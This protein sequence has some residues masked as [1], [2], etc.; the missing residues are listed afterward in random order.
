[1]LMPK[2]KK[3]NLLATLGLFSI[4]LVISVALLA[5]MFLKKPISEFSLDTRKA[6]MVDSGLAELDTYPFNQSTLKVN[7]EQKINLQ[8]NTKD[9]SVDTIKLIFE[10]IADKGLLDK[11]R[12][13]FSGT[14]PAELEINKQEVIESICEKDCYTVTLLLNIKNSSVAF[15]TH[16]QMKTISQLSFTPKNEGSL[17]IKISQDSTAIERGTSVDILQKPSVLDFQYY[18]TENGIDRSQCSFEYTAWGE[19]QN[20]W[21]TRKYSVQPDRCQWY[22][23][24][25]LKE[26]SQKCIDND[27]VTANNNYFYLYSNDVCLN[28]PSNGGSLYIIWNKNKYSNVTWIDVSN[29]PN[30]EDYYHKKVEGNIDQTNGDWII[31]N[32]KDF[33]NSANNK[34]P[35]SIE[36]SREYFFRLYST[37]NDGEHISSVRYYVNYCS[38]NQSSYKNC[39]EACGEGSDQSKSCAPGLTCSNNVCRNSSNPDNSLCLTTPGIQSADRSCNQ[40][41]ANSNECGSGLSCFWNHCRR[42]NNLESSSC[43]TKSTSSTSNNTI[44]KSAA[45]ITKGGNNVN[46]YID[47]SGKTVLLPSEAYVL[48]T[49]GCNQGC[50]G[51]RD[52]D[53]DMRCYKGKCR[54]VDNPEEISCAITSNVQKSA[55]SSSVSSINSTNNPTISP[56]ITKEIKEKNT[57]FQSGINKFLSNFSWQWLAFAGVIL[58]IA[59]ALIV[60]S[61]TNAKKDLW[62]TNVNSEPKKPEETI[63]IPEDK[64]LQF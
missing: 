47:R 34:G 59:I 35:L 12:I 22:Q 36:P 14:I 26:L 60:I 13:K 1:M 62:G 20:G 19:C 16:D 55:T 43:E 15:S 28:Q 40:Y 18:V 7:E 37:N 49:N 50:N 52:C 44:Q 31:V 56:S 33:T 4:V 32:A 53:A 57:V 3:S 23:E 63:K 17:K 64:P 48:S 29:S 8:I 30:F 5:T 21:Q 25:S 41:C 46:S 10:V 11:N 6:A 24:E 42:T 45:T 51:N 61:I 38:G 54:L 2:N 39:N 27:I 58:L 9:K